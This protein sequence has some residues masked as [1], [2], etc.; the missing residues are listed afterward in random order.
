[1]EVFAWFSFSPVSFQVQLCTIIIFV[2]PS[3][4]N[5]KTVHNLVFCI[6]LFDSGGMGNMPCFVL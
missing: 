4:E 2:Y 6:L 5:I 1:M 3:E